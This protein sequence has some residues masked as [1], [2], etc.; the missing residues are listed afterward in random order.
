MKWIVLIIWMLA[1]CWISDPNVPS[2]KV[3]NDRIS[4]LERVAVLHPI[5]V[6]GKADEC[7]TVS[8]KDYWFCRAALFEALSI[9]LGWW[10][11]RALVTCS[12]R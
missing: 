1:A 2:R 6:P 9:Q 10:I 12:R 5:P 8:D 4:C 3:A 7:V 11:T